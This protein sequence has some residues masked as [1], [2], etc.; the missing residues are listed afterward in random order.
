MNVSNAQSEPYE[1]NDQQY[2]EGNNEAG[3]Q[4]TQPFG[5]GPLTDAG[6][7]RAIFNVL[8]SYRYAITSAWSGFPAAAAAEPRLCSYGA[9]LNLYA[10]NT[11]STY[12]SVNTAGKHIS[13]PL[14]GDA[15]TSMP[16]RKHIKF[17]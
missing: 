10:R 13:I 1:R 7:R 14:T 4:G 6:E 11:D 17:S 2:G 9:C 8:D 3:L 16:S 12:I 15:K 5:S